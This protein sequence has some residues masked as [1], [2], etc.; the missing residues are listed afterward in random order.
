MAA[1]S[2]KAA[3]ADYAARGFSPIP[4]G[5]DKRPVAKEWPERTAADWDKH[6]VKTAAGV[7]LRTGYPL[8]E[9]VAAPAEA[10]PVPLFVVDIDRGNR[11]MQHWEALIAAHGEPDAPRVRTPGGGLHYYFLRDAATDGI[12]TWAL[13]I[14]AL[15]DTEQGLKRVPVGIDVRSDGGQVV[16]PPSELAAGRYEWEVPLDEAPLAPP[17]A[18]LIELLIT[19]MFPQDLYV[20]D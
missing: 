9:K 8:R 7:G 13:Q 17:P 11:G 20:L 5:S 18:W 1:L 6:W 15:S 19:K 16:V 14:M 3:A 2:I 4:V 10:G 12:G